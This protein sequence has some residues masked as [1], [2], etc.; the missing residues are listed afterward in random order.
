MK[1]HV[2][3]FKRHREEILSRLSALGC[4]VSPGSKLAG[5][6]LAGRLRAT[7]SSTPYDTAKEA[8]RGLILARD[9][10][11]GPALASTNVNR[12]PPVRTA[13]HPSQIAGTVPRDE[14][15][16]LPEEYFRD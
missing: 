2:S 3:G 7:R 14:D 9:D 12:A 11:S 1:D 10:R 13:P 8:K 15:D 16:D 4:D 6:T 5:T